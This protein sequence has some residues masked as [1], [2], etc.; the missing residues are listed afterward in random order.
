MTP[1]HDLPALATLSAR[2]GADPLLIQGAGGNT[3][4]KDGAQMWIKAS[5]TLL[6]DALTR[7]IFVPVDLPAMRSAL[8]A[9]DPSAD[10]PA[11]FALSGT[12]RPSI[13]TSLHAVF[14][15]RIVVH[16]HCVNSIAL[17]ICADAR[18]RLETRLAGFNWASVPYAKPGAQ[19][20][21]LVT[22]AL[23]PKT[24]VMLLGNHGLIVAAQSV[25]DAD[26][27]LT[28]VVA[29]LSTPPRPMPAPDMA[30][31]THRASIDYIPCA[32]THPLHGVAIDPERLAA[33]LGG[34]LYP[35]HVIFC[36]V[37][38]LALGPQETA[39]AVAAKRQSQGLP[40]PVFLLVPGIG[41]L[42]RADASPGALALSRC[43]GD[44]LARLPPG[45]Q[46]LW[47]SDAQNA[48]L[49]NWDA[50]K[51]RQSLNAN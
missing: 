19:L 11:A 24:D 4:V 13:E 33:A 35:D 32:A 43:L 23:G 31:L 46:P 7:D 25:A 6:A 34:S 37:G 18:A 2:I 5:G 30:A 48:D 50:E 40:A 1:P 51:Y 49:L 9:G 41:A 20:A 45:G 3:S 36:G 12:L 17:M 22:A 10:Q 14:S 21:A 26:A 39:E 38:A 27:L 28:A 47:L 15:Q 8:A 42:I 44:V 16:V 29:A